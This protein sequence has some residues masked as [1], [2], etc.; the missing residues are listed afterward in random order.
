MSNTFKRSLILLSMAIF[1]AMAFAGGDDNVFYKTTTTTDA[2]G[3]ITSIETSSAGGKII[4]INISYTDVKYLSFVPANYKNFTMRVNIFDDGKILQRLS[5]NGKYYPKSGSYESNETPTETV[6]DVKESKT[7]T[8][9]VDKFK[10]KETVEKGIYPTL[11]VKIQESIYDYAVVSGPNQTTPGVT[12]K[13]AL[14]NTFDEKGALTRSSNYFAFTKWMVAGPTMNYDVIERNN[15]SQTETVTSYYSDGSV[16][17]SGSRSSTTAKKEGTWITYSPGPENKIEKTEEY[18][19]GELISTSSPDNTV[20]LSSEETQQV[21]KMLEQG[22]KIDL[23]SSK[24]TSL[25]RRF[26]KSAGKDN[27]NAAKVASAVLANAGII[28]SVFDGNTYITPISKNKFDV[29]IFVSTAKKYAETAKLLSD[30]LYNSEGLTKLIFKD[31]V[32]KINERWRTSKTT[33]NLLSGSEIDLLVEPNGVLDY[34]IFRA[35]QKLILNS[36]GTSNIT[37]G[38]LVFATDTLMNIV[39]AVASY[40]P[41]VDEDNTKILVEDM[42]A[43]VIETVV[44]QMKEDKDYERIFSSK[45]AVSEQIRDL[46]EVDLFKVK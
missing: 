45:G 33:K 24:T 31:L 27:L 20:Q 41:F 35:N 5:L 4:E 34:L 1:S 13:G 14:I 22:E 36:D 26:I 21:M 25:L 10:I 17:Y 3:N 8:L 28:E 37:R 11:G 40:E 15:D 30:E 9:T 18:K 16:K 12:L 32:D 23:S 46:K 44:E 7:Y 29:A 19:D 38:A 42:K 39:D 2:N 6:F 43:K